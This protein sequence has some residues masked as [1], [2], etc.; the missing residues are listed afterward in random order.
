M[1]FYLPVIEAYPLSPPEWPILAF[2]VVVCSRVGCIHGSR[3]T[4]QLVHCKL[5]SSSGKRLKLTLRESV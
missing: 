4:S 1:L 2:M 5:H 3:V